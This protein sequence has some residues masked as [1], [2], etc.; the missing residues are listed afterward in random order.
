MGLSGQASAAKGVD[1]VD[2]VASA[3]AGAIELAHAHSMIVVITVTDFI[4]DGSRLPA[5]L[6]ALH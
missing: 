1:A 5:F 2:P 3:E 4:T 6:V